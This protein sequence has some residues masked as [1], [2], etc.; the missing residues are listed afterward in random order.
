MTATRIE[1][2]SMGEMTVPAS[3]YYGAQTARAL[4]NFP[5]S[6]LRLPRYMIQALGRI[7]QAAATVNNELGLLDAE[8]MGGIV[9]AAQEVIDGKLDDHFP[10]DIFQT[11]SGTSS[12][13]N[14]N[15]VIANRA[16]EI[17]GH[18]IGSKFVHP[19][20]HVN[21]GQS[22]NDVFPTAIHVAVYTAVM[23]DLMPALEAV[24]ATLE[25]KSKDFD[26]IVKAGR[27]HLMDATPVRLGQEFGGYAQQVRKSMG[28]VKNA[29]EHV[30]ELALGG[31][32]VGTG[33]NMH[34][35]F[36]RSVIE[37]LAKETGYPFEEAENHF[38]AQSAQDSLVALSG[39]L[40]VTAVALTKIANDVRW[41]GSGPR[42]GLGELI[43]PEIQPGSSIMPGKVNP[44]LCEAVV[45]VAAQVIG[46][47]AAITVG[48]LDGHFELLVMLPMMAHNILESVSILS[49]VCHAFNNRCLIGLQADEKR[50]AEL[51]ER[52]LMN[53]TPLAPVIG[54]D[55]AA[56]V[57]KKAKLE[58]K[59]IRQVALEM[60]LLDAA[61][62]DELLDPRSMT[63][64]GI[65]M[66]EAGG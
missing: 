51:V 26:H 7:K 63:V 57:A 29:L 32:A 22:S 12:N 35:E 14:T 33:V 66:G 16:S 17:L 59:S 18:A 24:L 11:G 2:D 49:G 15:E 36:A 39:A 4:A 46:N 60:Q 40:R 8:R 56:A 27:T 62:L 10:V 30:A 21:K 41:L 31:T 61:K 28:H 23:K 44:V 42:C 53:V 38:E 3:A 45:Q 43:L 25:Q 48:G 55:K 9:E 54:Y 47:D 13:M 37:V 20:D 19:N 5:I 6:G 1:K 52:S 65:S 34:P 58:D 50:C 64:P